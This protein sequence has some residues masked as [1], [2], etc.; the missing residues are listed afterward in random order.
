MKLRKWAWGGAVEQLSRPVIPRYRCSGRARSQRKCE[1]GFISD[2]TNFIYR[3]L[4]HYCF[5]SRSWRL[6]QRGAILL[7]A[8][9]HRDHY[10][11]L[12]SNG[13]VATSQSKHQRTS[14]GCC[15]QSQ[16]RP[17]GVVSLARLHVVA[18]SETHRRVR[19][20][21]ETK[22]FHNP[23]LCERASKMAALQM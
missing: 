18:P 11:R 10:S 2:S 13:S 23:R 22:K 19:Q 7:I 5:L 1:A 9:A 3:R 17:S 16:T 4:T 15:G 6:W 21:A 12:F 14:W 8:S 20:K